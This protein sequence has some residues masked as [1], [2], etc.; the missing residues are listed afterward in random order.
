MSS[1][2]RFLKAKSIKMNT[3]VKKSSNIVKIRKISKPNLHKY[4]EQSKIL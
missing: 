2:E 4:F 3:T 1:K